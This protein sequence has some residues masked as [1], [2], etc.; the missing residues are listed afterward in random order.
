MTLQVSSPYVHVEDANGN[1]YVAAKLY[2]YLV[3]TTT[4]ASIYSNEALST[5]LTNPMTS[6]SA[7]NF[8]RA[9]IAAGTY[10]LRA[11]TSAGVLIWTEDNIDTGL[12]AGTGALPIARGGTGSTTAAAARAALDVPSNS[13]LSVLSTSITTL[14]SQIQGIISEPQGY[15]TLTSNTPVIASDVTAATSVYYTPRRGNIIPIWT[16]S[17]YTLTTFTELTLALVANHVASTIYDLFVMSD[18]GTVRLVSGVAWN[19]SGAGTGSRGS[20]AG[21]T[22]LERKNGLWT[23]K[24]AMTMRYGATTISNVPANTATYVGSIFMDGTNGQVSCHRSYGQSRKWGLWNA[25][26]RSPLWLKLGDPTAT[27]TYNAA[28]IRQSRADATNT[29][30]I[31]CGLPEEGVRTEF[32]QLLQ[33]PSSNLNTIMQIGVGLNSTTAFSGTQGRSSGGDASSIK[34]WTMTAK[35]TV[36]PFIGLNNINALESAQTTAPTFYGSEA[37]MLLTA[38]WQG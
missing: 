6:D 27:W 12:Q 18:S 4:L 26:S 2:V 9:Y 30:A 28:T 31:F 11:E 24:N 16:G 33:Q 32:I 29:L 8:P 7:G 36:D 10:K 34:G 23:N 13:E 38:N 5:P 14:T 20:G 25:Y 3:T 21:T 15:L 35:Y 17:A 1:P 19:N 37:S 22:E